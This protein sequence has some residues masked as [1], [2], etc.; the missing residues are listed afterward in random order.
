MEM[1]DIIIDF[2]NREQKQRFLSAASAL[3]TPYRVQIVKARK[4]R[5][6]AQNRYYW[7]VVIEY[8]RAYC[9]DQGEDLD[10]EEVH[11]LLKA[12]FLR[13]QINDRVTGRVIGQAIRSTASLNT[14]EFIDYIDRC[15]VFMA[16]MGIVVP[17]PSNYYERSA[18]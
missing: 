7:G 13:R 15:A 9:H 14:A 8:L 17:D 5:S 6:D 2:G 3:S 18:A 11:E 12:K 10:A 4:R 1:K 16:E